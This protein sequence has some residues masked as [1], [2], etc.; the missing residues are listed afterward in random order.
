M[1]N[2]FLDVAFQSVNGQ[3]RAREVVGEQEVNEKCWENSSSCGELSRDGNLKIM[4][5]HV[6]QYLPNLSA[7]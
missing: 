1:N 4:C 7:A 6:Q 3:E 2:P 5:S